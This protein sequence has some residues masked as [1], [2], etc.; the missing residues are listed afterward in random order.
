MNEMPFLD[1]DTPQFPQWKNLRWPITGSVVY[2]QPIR[3][4]LSL[5]RQHCLCFASVNYILAEK[6]SLATADTTK[7][8]GVA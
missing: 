4:H 5:Q 6:S 1:T 8:L 2:F 3:L 7:Y